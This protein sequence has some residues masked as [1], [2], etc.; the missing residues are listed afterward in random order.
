MQWNE[1]LYGGHQGP[2]EGAGVLLLHGFGGSPC[3]LQELAQRLVDQGYTVALPLLAGH[4]RTPEDME[5]SRW[6][7]WTTDVEAGLPI[8]PGPHRHGD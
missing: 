7:E 3:S 6:T 4:G 1:P 2:K 5:A 8:G